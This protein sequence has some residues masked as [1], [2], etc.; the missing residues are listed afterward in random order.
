MIRE[1]QEIRRM[2][3]DIV[4]NGTLDRSRRLTAT[5]HRKDIILGLL[6]KGHTIIN[7]NGRADKSVEKKLLD[8]L[9]NI[10]ILKL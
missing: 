5:E 7:F 6:K 4:F 8:E 9:K 1:S 3:Y 10:K 2:R